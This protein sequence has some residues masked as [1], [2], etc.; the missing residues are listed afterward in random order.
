M[1]INKI[2]QLNI[3]GGLIGLVLTNPRR[4]LE[5]CIMKENQDGWNAVYFTHHKDT[6]IFMSILKLAVLLCNLFLWTW[7]AGYMILFEREGP[8]GSGQQI[9]PQPNF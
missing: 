4:A 1:K 2:V 6:N 5:S 8:R 9:P 3:S 7:G